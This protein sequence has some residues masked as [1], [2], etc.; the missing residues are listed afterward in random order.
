MGRPWSFG[1]VHVGRNEGSV[2]VVVIVTRLL[3]AG[4]TA[5]IDQASPGNCDF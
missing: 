4:A 2:E 5:R 3:P 1:H